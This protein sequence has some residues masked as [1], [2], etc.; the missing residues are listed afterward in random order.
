MSSWVVQVAAWPCARAR[1]LHARGGHGGR[2][3]LAWGGAGSW[4]VGVQRPRRAQR[5]HPEGQRQAAQRRARH[6]VH[7]GRHRHAQ[8]RGQ[9]H[10]L[11]S[12][13]TGAAGAGRVSR[14]WSSPAFRP[15]CTRTDAHTRMSPTHPPT[16]PQRCRPPPLP[17]AHAPVPPAL[18]LP[19]GSIALLQR[20]S[21][22]SAAPLTSSTL[23]ALAPPAQPVAEEA[24]PRRANTDMDLRSRS[25]SSSASDG[26]LRAQ[27][28]V[29]AVLRGKGGGGGKRPARPSPAQPSPAQPSPAQPNDALPAHPKRAVLK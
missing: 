15:P 27:A 28:H 21:T 4:P 14:R 25:N 19:P 29:G 11:R 6:G 5:A 17:F 24:A 22:H 7:L 12:R 23:P 20:S 26:S 8:R 18:T 9:C 2:S 16:P 3:G 10:H 13:P 1:G